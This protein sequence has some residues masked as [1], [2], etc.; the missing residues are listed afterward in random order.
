MHQ[1]KQTNGVSRSYFNAD[2]NPIRFFPRRSIA[3]PL[4][5]FP[6]PSSARWSFVPCLFISTARTM[7]WN[8][9]SSSFLR[10]NIPPRSEEHTSELPSLM[11]ISYAVICLKQKIISSPNNYMTHTVNITQCHVD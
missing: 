10:I 3:L 1:P 2:Q 6:L 8:D 4:D 9:G 5:C 11:R 7:R